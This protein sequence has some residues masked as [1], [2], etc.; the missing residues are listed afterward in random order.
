MAEHLEAARHEPLDFSG[1]GKSA[2]INSIFDEVKFGTYAFQI[3]R[4][5][6]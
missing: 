2:T 6:L 3:A 4:F 1:V 5:T